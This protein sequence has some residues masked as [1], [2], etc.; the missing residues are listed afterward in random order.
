MNYLT[1]KMVESGISATIQNWFLNIPSVIYAVFIMLA[2]FW[3]VYSIR[4]AINKK[5]IKA[6]REIAE[7]RG[8]S[9]SET[10]TNQQEAYIENKGKTHELIPK[11]F[12]IFQTGGWDIQNIISTVKN[13]IKWNIFEFEKT[14]GYGENKKTIVFLCAHAYTN[15][16]FPDFVLTKENLFN[17][18]AAF[19]KYEDINFDT[20]PEFSKKYY[21]KSEKETEIRKLFNT[22]V[23]S[24]FEQKKEI[25]S[26][27]VKGSDILIYNISGGKKPEDY[28]KL[29]D[30]AERIVSVL[31]KA[32][33][34][35]HN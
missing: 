22:E 30:E 21:L 3:I 1:V 24:Y 28:I 14:K 17:K 12:N 27:E 26:I 18:I 13:S 19:F 33:S 35:M 25:Y 34:R 8:F 6:I 5:R 29:F 31:V 11:N 20:N 32:E 2:L 7:S 23:L 9:F 10:E 16:V 4:S 15:A